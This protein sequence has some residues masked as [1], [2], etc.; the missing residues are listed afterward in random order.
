MK[1]IQNISTLLHVGVR[2]LQI[3]DTL[4]VCSD[5]SSMKDFSS[6]CNLVSLLIDKNIISF[7]TAGA[8]NSLMQRA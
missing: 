5:F 4:E 8:N 2:V 3:E 7:Q 1:K 6:S